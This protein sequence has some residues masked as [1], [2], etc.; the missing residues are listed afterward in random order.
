[1]GV[2]DVELEDDVGV[3]VDV[4]GDGTGHG[5]G[6][7]PVFGGGRSELVAVVVVVGHGDGGADLCG[8][9]VSGLVVCVRGYC[10]SSVG[11]CQ[12]PVA[13]VVGVGGCAFGD[14]VH[15]FGFGLLI[16]GEVVGIAV[17]VD[18]GC[19]LFVGEREQR[20]VG[21]GRKYSFRRSKRVSHVLRHL[22]HRAFGAEGGLGCAE[23]A[24]LI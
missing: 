10:T 19:A 23:K 20:V 2:V 22:P 13:V 6:Y 16:A 11:D 17:G 8:F 12:E 5:F 24:S 3:L 21:V 4:A 18:D 15:G 9:A 14:A 7:A 1:M